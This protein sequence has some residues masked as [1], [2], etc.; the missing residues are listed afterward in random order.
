M[1]RDTEGSGLLDPLYFR[2]V[3][4]G[5]RQVKM[6]MGAG[7]PSRACRSAR[8]GGA[9]RYDR[10]MVAK[11]VLV[12]L[13][14]QYDFL[15][16]GAL[17]VP[18]GDAVVPIVNRVASRFTNVV[19]TQDWHPR[20]HLSFASSHVGRQPFEVVALPYGEQ[21]LWP[22]HCV[23]GTPGAALSAALD[24]PH[25][26][27][28]IRKGYHADTDSYSAFLEADRRTRTG[29]HGYLAERGIEEVFCA[30]LA[31]DYCVT[32]TALDA[33]R[34]GFKATVLMDACRAIDVDGSLGRA[35]AA[36]RDARVTILAS[37]Q[38]G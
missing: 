25:A 16:G 12:V 36:L 15:P 18:Q 2:G 10:R 21:V 17:A 31:T 8:A 1:A 22:D 34:F 29:L 35:V 26:Q 27:L 28:V 32:W 19:L 4:A 3:P 5:L 23:Q 7:T 30:G 14:V 9:W 13:D 24:V 38:V 11:S 20:G 33:I 37:D 6:R